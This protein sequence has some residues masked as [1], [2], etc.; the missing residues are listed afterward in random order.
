M[1]RRNQHIPRAFE[2]SPHVR[3]DGP[4]INLERLGKHLFSPRAWGWSE[5]FDPCPAKS[6]VLPTCVGMVRESAARVNEFLRSPHVRGDGPHG[7]R[8]SGDREQFSPRAWG[9]SVAIG[10]AAN[11]N[12]VLPTCVGMVR[13]AHAARFAW[14]R[15]PHV[16]GDGPVVT[17]DV[18][19]GA[20]FSPRAWGWSAL[21]RERLTFW[22]V[23]P[24][25][26]GMVRIR[27]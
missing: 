12:V 1:V 4:G 8:T 6:K 7:W 10:A 24:T 20:E 16:R 23:L 22:P 21:R 3:G 25:C 19:H 11:A 13:R 27:K 18:N 5:A 15:S 26:V 17:G 9:W 2:R 14:M